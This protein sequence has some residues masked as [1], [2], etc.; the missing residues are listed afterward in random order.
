MGLANYFSNNELDQLEQL[1]FAQ[2]LLSLIQA[3]LPL[4]NAIEIMIQSTPKSWQ[5][6]LNEVRLQLQQGNSLSYCL[7]GRIGKFSP[8]FTN[9][10]RV[11][12]RSGDLG[13]ALETISKQLE[14]QIELRRKVI[15]SLTYP[16]ITLAS[17][18]ALIIVMMLWV[19]PVF[20]EVFDNFQAIL[21][22]QTLF[23]IS[24]SQIFESYLFELL[25]I[26][27]SIIIIFI[28]LWQKLIGLQR[29]CDRLILRLPLLGNLFRLATLGGWCRTLG[30]L[31]NA[32]LALPDALRV[33]AQSSNNWVIHDFSAEI[34]KHLT[35]GYPINEALKKSDPY[36]LLMD[37]E[38]RLL[39]HIAAQS[40]ALAPML[41][42]RAL[43]LDH[44]LSS[45]LQALSGNLEP[46]LILF[47]GFVI[48][49]LVIILYLPI[50][51]LGQIV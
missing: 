8:E 32:G 23:L 29:Y 34:F 14:S 40:G 7:G 51:N 30:H 2:Q 18:F 11:S 39:L 36:A 43:T 38:T 47:I 33:T 10:I 44:Q 20:K 37:T 22:A 19:I 5:I 4:L 25:I 17:S 45:K 21:P 50:F 31:I 9:L 13:L 41:N 16:L 27:T 3:G 15:Q 6:W 35:R 26:S 24:I 12:E 49:G 28:V 48:G 42:K 1:H 46:F